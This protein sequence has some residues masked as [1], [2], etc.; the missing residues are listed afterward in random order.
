MDRLGKRMNENKKVIKMEFKSDATIVTFEDGESI[1]VVPEWDDGQ[2]LN[3][4]EF[5]ERFFPAIIE[6]II[7]TK[8][9]I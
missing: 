3:K 8:S 9:E 7:F 2:K 5:R 1:S 4:N 6:E